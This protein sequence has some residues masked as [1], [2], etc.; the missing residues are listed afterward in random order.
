MSYRAE[1]A[2]DSGEAPEKP[3]KTIPDRF[4]VRIDVDIKAHH[5]YQ[6]A[7]WPLETSTCNVYQVDDQL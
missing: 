2:E 3:G 6:R 7:D 4:F 1:A 5:R